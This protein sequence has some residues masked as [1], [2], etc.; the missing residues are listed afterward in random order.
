MVFPQSGSALPRH[1]SQLYQFALEGIL[2]F[3]L[4]WLYARQ[5]RRLGQVS[6]AFLVG[7]GVLRFTAEYFREP[8]GFLGLLALNMSMGQWLCLP[9]VAAGLVLGWWAGRQPVGVNQGR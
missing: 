8:D 5:P 4:L 1:P 2:L 6:A 3:V 7:Y 9:M